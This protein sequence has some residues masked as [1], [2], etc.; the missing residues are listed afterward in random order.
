MLSE[1]FKL[2]ICANGIEDISECYSN[3]IKNITAFEGRRLIF[4]DDESGRFETLMN[5]Y[6]NSTYIKDIESFDKTIED[7]KPE[8]N[9]RLEQSGETSEQLFI[10]I[11]EFN[12]F[13]NMIT[14]EQADFMRKIFKYID[15]PKSGIYFICG[16]NVN[17]MKINDRL[18]MSLVVN[19]ENYIICP[20]SYEKAYSKIETLSL[21]PSIK[22][23]GCYFCT[24]SKT[25]EMRW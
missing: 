2:C 23:K 5:G 3:I 16:F 20:D 1:T 17:G 13:F 22:T 6:E 7:L 19:A 14:D 24:G 12:G 8:L 15:S 18:F 10:V 9:A 25:A 11:P 4:I 21:I